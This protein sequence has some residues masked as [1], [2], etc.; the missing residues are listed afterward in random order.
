MA[1][2]DSSIYIYIYIPDMK[3]FKLSMMFSRIAAVVDTFRR[4]DMS[5][6]VCMLVYMLVYSVYSVYVSV[7]DTLSRWD[8]SV[9]IRVC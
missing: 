3:A 9:C 1:L 2:T 8:M 5:V 6:Y 7:V 4:W